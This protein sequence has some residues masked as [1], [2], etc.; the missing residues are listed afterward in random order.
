MRF[1]ALLFIL[2]STSAS[3]AKGKAYLDMEDDQIISVFNQPGMNWKNCAKDPACRSVAWPDNTA[4]IEIISD[5]PQRM[6]V[7]SPYTGE[8][9]EEEYLEV[10]Y[11]YKRTV[12]GKVYTQEG[13]GWVDAAYVSLKKRSSFYGKTTEPSK[14]CPPGSKPSGKGP[15]EVQKNLAPFERALSNTSVTET[16]KLLKEHVGACVIDPK[17]N[18]VSA[19][20]GNPYDNLVLPHLQKKGVPQ[21][22]KED[23]KAMTKKDLIDIDALARTIYAEM[24]QCYKHGLHYP[25]T[26]AKIAVNRAN[27]DRRA[28]EFIRGTHSSAKGD[29][30][31]V[32]TSPTQFSLWLTTINGK[33]NNSLRQA[34]CPP[35]DKSKAFWTG[36]APPPFELDIW[37][38]TLRIATEAV[39]FPKKFNSR[40]QQIKQ[41][42]YTSGMPGFYGMK[43]VFPWIEDRKVSKNACVQVWDDGAKS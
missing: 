12:D 38:N 36:N 13:Q 26:V 7:E 22:I 29:L 8:L 18:A 25:M 21:I 24:A 11:R 32:A 15:K 6:Q 42:H 33:P 14:D 4:E 16:T 1:I 3:W 2:F 23:G 28:K 40:T 41:F 37:E 17:K 19:G 10:K 39:L 43:Q 34:L 9:Q 35:A 27:E 20:S 5:Y 31:K 30:A